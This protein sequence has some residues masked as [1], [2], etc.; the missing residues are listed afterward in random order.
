MKESQSQA[1]QIQQTDQKI[2]LFLQE[3]SQIL[4]ETINQGANL[5]FEEMKKN[6]I[7]EQEQLSNAEEKMKQ[8]I[9]ECTDTTLDIFEQ[10]IR[11]NF[12]DCDELLKHKDQQKINKNYS[13][14]LLKQ[15]EQ[16][17]Q[18]HSQQE[19]RKKMN[20]ISKYIQKDVEEN[21]QQLKDKVQKLYH[22]DEVMKDV[23]LIEKC[24]SYLT[25]AQNQLEKSQSALE[26]LLQ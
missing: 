2:N 11:N 6:K 17:K 20:Q 7:F 15:V 4:Q 18:E 5:L 8:E 21:Y 24:N 13:S 12:F 16:Q 22:N 19:E 10:Y 23:V 9:K 14:N 1:N 3:C 25:N 26:E